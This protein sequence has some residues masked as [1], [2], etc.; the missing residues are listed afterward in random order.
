MCGGMGGPTSQPGRTDTGPNQV[1]PPVGLVSWAPDPEV[2]LQ[3][4]FWLDWAQ[5]EAHSRSE[6]VAPEAVRLEAR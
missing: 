1:F 3:P 2:A 4:N 6:A 5:A